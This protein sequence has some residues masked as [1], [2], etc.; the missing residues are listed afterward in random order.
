MNY[1]GTRGKYAISSSEAIARGI[2]SDGGL[3]VPESFPA[4]SDSEIKALVEM[5]Y[6]ERAKAVLAKYLTDFSASELDE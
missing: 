6:C 2:A 5:N 3:F 4:L 1:T